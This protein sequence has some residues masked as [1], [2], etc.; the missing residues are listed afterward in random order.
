[1]ARDV[2]CVGR[3][4]A[5]RRPRCLP[6]LMRTART[7][8]VLVLSGDPVAAA[9]LG[10]LI[11][12]AGLAPVFAR[13][14]E[15]PEE[16]IAR[17]RP[18][19]VVLVDGALEAAR[20]DL[21][22]A[23]AARARVA[24]AVFVAPRAGEPLAPVAPVAV[25]RGIPRCDFPTSVAALE[26][27]LEAARASRW[28]AR[29]GDRRR[30]VPAA[31]AHA[32]HAAHPGHPHPGDALVYLDRHGRRWNVYDRRSGPGR[33]AGDDA[34]AGGVVT[35]ERVFV[36]DTGEVRTYRLGDGE[37]AA[38]APDDLGTQLERAVPTA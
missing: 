21:F 6:P 17:V 11:E 4:P 35:V 8:N 22:F 38:V 3:L 9:L 12:L 13:A 32:A 31:T 14:D 33:R 18:H 29:G 25:A 20:S 27:M 36:S 7:P 19:T 30:G 28:W 2:M 10:M 16:A 34:G 1:M 23:A 5:A 24:M 26:R 37:A 15:R